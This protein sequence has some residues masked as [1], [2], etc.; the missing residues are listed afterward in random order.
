MLIASKEKEKQ[1]IVRKES[2]TNNANSDNYLLKIQKSIKEI[3][4]GNVAEQ[5]KTGAKT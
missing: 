4:Y 1:N 2:Q 5:T 3:D